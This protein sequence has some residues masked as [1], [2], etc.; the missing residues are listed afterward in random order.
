MS[1]HLLELQR[2]VY[3]ALT[4]SAALVNQVNG[5]FDDVPQDVDYPF[6]ALGDE[7]SIDRSTKTI[8]GQEVTIT[9]HVFSENKGKL[10]TKQIMQAI[11]DVLHDNDMI[12]QNANLVNMRFEFSDIVIENDGV[13]R[14]GVM[15]FRAVI[16]D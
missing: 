8:D 1:F 14:H 15:R 16:F 6:V 7:T 2:S 9:I 3:T 12:V 13:T 10:V 11:Y 5:I 4:S